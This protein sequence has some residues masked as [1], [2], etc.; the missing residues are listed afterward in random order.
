M[1]CDV[2][3]F[4]EAALEGQFKEASEATINLPD[5]TI[6]V[7]E[8]FLRWLYSGESGLPGCLGNSKS[9]DIRQA[10]Y[11]QTIELYGF[12]GKID[13]L[14]LKTH[15]IENMFMTIAQISDQVP[16]MSCI[17]RAYTLTPPASGLRRLL[18]ACGTF[19]T[20][21]EWYKDKENIETL[22][23]TPEYAAQLVAAWVAKQGQADPFFYNTAD[24]FY[25]ADMM[26]LVGKK[27]TTVVVESKETGW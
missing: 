13:C 24:Y 1:L 4:F 12:A 16:N 22:A 20:C 23:Q 18:V 8:T 11:A 5:D 19:R 25:D 17:S 9:E 10:E 15:L 3:H 7:I 27:R 21:E 14:L 6:P 2:S 26:G